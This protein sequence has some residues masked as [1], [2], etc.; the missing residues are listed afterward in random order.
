MFYCQYWCARRF[1]LH[2]AAFILVSF[3]VHG[4]ALRAAG[5]A[6]AANLVGVTADT[7]G[8]AVPLAHVSVTNDSTGLERQTTSDKEGNFVLPDLPPGTYTLTAQRADFPRVRIPGLQ[9]QAG[10]NSTV[11]VQFP[12]LVTLRGTVKD[13]KTSEPIA[14]AL[15]SIRA[16]NLQAITDDT[17]RFE[18]SKVQPG[19]VELYK[20]TVGYGLLKTKLQ[21]PVGGGPEVELQIGQEALKR[22]DQITVA[23]GP[24]DPI[25]T[26][27]P[28]EQ[29]LQ[30][31]ELKNLSGLFGD[32][33]RSIH[34]LPGV[35]APDDYYAD[36]AGDPIG[37]GTK[38]TK[39]GLGD[40]NWAGRL[41]AGLFSNAEG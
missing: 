16:Q 25:E 32:P 24:Y 41:E 3:L 10:V 17:G 15:V 33:F 12:A 1:L 27:A 37:S 31:S 40:L 14:K 22:N 19:E 36:F 11:T 6:M 23:S 34:S 30:A 18:L 8:A 4:L 7:S 20:T 26:E 29:V 13:F 5:Q 28:T 2:G 38:A 39:Y 35:A 21:V 9:L